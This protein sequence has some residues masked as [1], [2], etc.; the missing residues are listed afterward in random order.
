MYGMESPW[1][2]EKLSFL[3]QLWAEGKTSGQIATIMQ[4]TRSAIMGKVRRLELP[5]R[6]S[7]AEAQRRKRGG[8]VVRPSRSG[9]WA[10]RQ[11][12]DP[13][14]LLPAPE[15][16]AEGGLSIIELDYRH[17]RAVIGKGDDGLARYCGKPKRPPLQVG[18]KIAISAFCQ[19]HAELY[20]QPLKR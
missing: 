14:S 6:A 16:I 15:P 17:C 2:E 1:T 7:V 13:A 4:M 5:H 19:E 9:G 8:S 12:P 10:I 20:Y 11:P 3:R 18:Q